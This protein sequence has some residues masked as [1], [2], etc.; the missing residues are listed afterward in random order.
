MARKSRK[1]YQIEKTKSIQE[2]FPEASSTQRPE[3]IPKKPKTAQI[4]L[5]LLAFLLY[6]NTISFDYTLDDKLAIT[7]ND[8]TKKGIDGIYDLLTNDMFV[9][10]YGRQKS[11]VEG[12]RY[13]P[14]SMVMF[15]IEWEFFPNNPH[16]SHFLNALFYAITALLL[17]Y[18]LSI[19]FPIDEKKKWYLTLPF[20]ATALYIAHP[21]HT[22]VVANIKSRDEIMDVLFGLS[23]LIFIYKYLQQKHL[24]YL[25]FSAGCFF[26][27][28]CSKESAVVF[29][30]VFVLTLIF[31]PKGNLKESTVALMPALVAIVAYGII[32]DQMLGEMARSTV[33]KELMNKPYLFAEGAEKFATI[34]FTMGIYIK[35]L[36]FP[37]P[38]THDYYPWHPLADDLYKWDKANFPYLDFSNP[39]V[40][41]SILIYVGLITY[42]IVGFFNAITG[43]KRSIFAYG[44]LLYLGTFVLFTNL[45]FSI[46]AYMNERFMY[47]PS[48]GFCIILG[49]LISEK[50]PQ[51]V[52]NPSVVTFVLAVILAGYSY[53]TIT[54]NKAWE[55]DFTLATTDVLVSK[56]SAKVNMSAGGSLV[57]KAKETIIPQK[58]LELTK[59]AIKYLYRSIE[60]YPTYIQPMLLMGNAYYE[61][62][63]Y[64]NSMYYFE[65]C[66]K[67]DP[68]YKFA[69]NN[70]LHLGDTLTKLGKYDLAIKSYTTLI[71]YK[72]DE[73]RAY[74][75]LGE[76]YGKN[77]GNFTKSEEYLRMALQIEPKNTDILQK[78]GVVNAMKGQPQKAL[79]YFQKAIEIDPDNA[80]I[81]MNIGITYKNLGQEEK[82]ENYLQKAFEM[83]PKLRG[84]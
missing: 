40:L 72:K 64:P 49:Y 56:N 70:L 21:L 24:K 2:E 33:H 12:G 19:I 66:L 73:M 43:K 23:T 46:G 31:F 71:N 76:L 22:E 65:N 84:Q 3:L 39:I 26:L 25:L 38:L 50:L 37:H 7:H 10:F 14:L 15:A 54:R 18:F 35:L 58:K 81:V 44:I 30:G 1:K 13:R 67:I 47:I 52:K 51:K 74:S 36:L 5:F 42:G 29:F 20:V 8:F 77:L 6:A 48:L 82:G 41:I 27:A 34:L 4:A 45:F 11:L 75:S 63:D 60:L 83:N 61:I 57:D 28:L 16:I 17:Y 78:L 62:N 59:Q 53:Q 9:G 79:E 80:H 55:N 69:V 32:R 68:N